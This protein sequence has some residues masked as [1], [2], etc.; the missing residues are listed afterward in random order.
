MGDPMAD[1]RNFFLKRLPDGRTLINLGCGTHMH[2]AWN[3]LDFSVY[4]RL[5]RHM[6]L[7]FLLRRFG[8]ISAARFAQF[9][10]VEP[11]IILWNLRR[12]IPFGDKT[13]DG[14]YHSHL[15][16]HIDREDALAFLVECYRV[17]RP[18]GVIRVVV[19]DLEKW[20]NAY[21]QS[22]SI[23]SVDNCIE[24]HEEVVGSLLVQLVQRGPTTRKMQKPMVRWLERVLL[25][26]SA[27]VGWQHRWMYDRLTLKAL[28]GKAGF[29]ECQLVTAWESRIDGWKE[30]GLDTHADGSEYKPESIWMEGVRPTRGQP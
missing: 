14:V 10:E 1:F 23:R 12:G 19:P 21:A 25:G 30:F 20:A 9:S 6:W 5:R 17:L 22:L 13:F 27:K 16:E 11:D 24:E 29:E 15:L 4:A 28:L 2:L 8:L 3:N 18:G 26:D 7:V